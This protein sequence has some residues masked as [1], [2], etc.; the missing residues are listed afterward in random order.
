MMMMKFA[1][2]KLTLGQILYKKTAS[3]K[4][5]KQKKIKNK[6]KKKCKKIE[7]KM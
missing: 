6:L 2:Q 1:V 4:K 7:E 5:Q 3:K